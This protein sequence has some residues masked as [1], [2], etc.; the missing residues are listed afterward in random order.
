MILPVNSL[1]REI[2]RV[3][4]SSMNRMPA[5]LRPITHVP[6][7]ASA[8][9]RRATLKASGLAALGIAAMSLPRASAAASPG[10]NLGA[11]TFYVGAG[12]GTTV[13][14]GYSSEPSE[15]AFFG[16]YIAVESDDDPGG[17][18]YRVSLFGDVTGPWLEA[19]SGPSGPFDGLVYFVYRVAYS[20]TSADESGCT[21]PIYLQVTGQVVEGD[22]EV[23]PDFLIGRFVNGVLVASSPV[24]EWF[25][26]FD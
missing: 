6:S 11:E 19:D 24:T 9:T 2:T 7:E 13:G 5:R 15:E 12:A 26:N 23:R 4:E 14:C 20:V 17:S 8:P 10:T 1:R 16:F 3:G 18:D 21:N 25:P 22:S